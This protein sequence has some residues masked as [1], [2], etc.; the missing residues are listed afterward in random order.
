MHF[1]GEVMK[2]KKITQKEKSYFPDQATLERVRKKLSDKS[3]E[4]GNFALPENATEVERVKYQICQMIARYMR[5]HEMLQKTLAKKLGID[6]SR[7]SEI[8]RGKIESFTLDRLI[9]YSE[10]IY[11]KMKLHIVAA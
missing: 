9:S 3:F 10:K 11:P 5:E 6:E 8:L 4:G 2:T 1:E 7:M